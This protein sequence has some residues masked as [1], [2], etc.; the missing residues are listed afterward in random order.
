MQDGQMIAGMVGTARA[1]MAKAAVDTGA[2]PRHQTDLET[3]LDS[4]RGMASYNQ[5]L[6]AMLAG[7]VIKLRGSL[8]PEPSE[9]K[10]SNLVPVPSGICGELREVQQTIA[11]SQGATL[12]LINL[13]RSHV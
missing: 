2:E 7:I 8:P 6:N 1:A 12:E 11:Q 10:G 4:L 9:A 3:L 5:E 13:I